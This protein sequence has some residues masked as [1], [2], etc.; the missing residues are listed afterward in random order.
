MC[1]T[2][3]ETSLPAAANPTPVAV[4]TKKTYTGGATRGS[5]IPDYTLIVGPVIERLV[6]RAQLGAEQHGRDNWLKSASSIAFYIDAHNHM[7][8]HMQKLF[9]GIEPEDDHIGA[10]LWACMAITHMQ[11]QMGSLMNALD[12]QRTED[13]VPV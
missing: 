7:R 3:N 2:P 1:Q 11:P 5:G 12:A 13:G 10:I 4:E 9:A 8:D 6:A